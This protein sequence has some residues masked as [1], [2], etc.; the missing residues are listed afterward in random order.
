M[1]VGIQS[2]EQRVGCSVV[3]CST[4]GK[5]GMEEVTKEYS[6]YAFDNVDNSGRPMDQKIC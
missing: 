3:Y 5:V 4:V 2:C 1:T 6:G